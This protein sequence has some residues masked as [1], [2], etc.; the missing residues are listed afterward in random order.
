MVEKCVVIII[1]FGF[2]QDLHKVVESMCALEYLQTNAKYC[3]KYML[4]IDGNCSTIQFI[5]NKILIN[6]ILHIIPELVY[7]LLNLNP[8]IPSSR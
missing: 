8:K 7:F 1:Q 5:Q 3:L 6:K 2:T 4:G